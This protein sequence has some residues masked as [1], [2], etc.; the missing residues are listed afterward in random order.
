MPTKSS[1]PIVMIVMGMAVVLLGNDE[2]ELKSRNTLFKDPMGVVRIE[3]K[4]GI[5]RGNIPPPLLEKKAD[6]SPKVKLEELKSLQSSVDIYIPKSNL[7]ENLTLK[8]YTSMILQEGIDRSNG[9]Y[10]A[11]LEELQNLMDQSR[12]DF[13]FSFLSFVSASQLPTAT[14]GMGLTYN[15]RAGIQATKIV[16]DGKKNFY[17][18]ENSTLIERFSKFKKLSSKKQ[19]M[20]YGTELYLRLLELQG[21]KDYIKK[22]QDINDNVYHITM[23]KYE[24]GVNDNAYDQINAKIDKLALEK[25]ALNLHYDLYTA[26]VSFKQAANMVPNGEIFLAWPKIETPSES[27]ELLQKR[28][29]EKNYQVE[30]ADTLFRIR[31]GDVLREKGEDDWQIG[32]DGFAGVGYSNTATNLT[33]STTQGANWIA[34]VQASHPIH[35]SSMDLSLEKKMVTALKEKN[36][37]LLAKQDMV[38]RV[39]KLFVECEREKQMLQLLLVQKELIE[40][41]LKITKF[42]LEG[43]LEPY[44]SYATSMK[45]MIEIEENILSSQVRQARNTFE[46]QL[47]TGDMD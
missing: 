39:S 2:I 9:Q 36:N 10:D 22:Y 47:L 11:K 34:T 16:Y 7:Q 24:H 27:V 1:K 28:A 44:T 17:L 46:L 40:R 32:F 30:L 12:Y 31:K 45:K 5:E 41:H 33:N 29:L 8:Q 13:V 15:G 38:Q 21:R 14:E 35:S 37:L 25:L 42:R 19:M 3:S 20:L 23:Q 26:T 18:N 43:G 4:K 6:I